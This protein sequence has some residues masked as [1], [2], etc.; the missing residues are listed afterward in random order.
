MTACAYIPIHLHRR[1]AVRRSGTGY[2]SFSGAEAPRREPRG[3]S[4]AAGRVGGRGISLVLN[5]FFLGSEVLFPDLK[6]FSMALKSF[7]LDSEVLFL[8]LKSFSRG[9]I[10]QVLNETLIFS[11]ADP[12]ADSAREKDFRM[13]L[14]ILGKVRE[15][16]FRMLKSFSPGCYFQNRAK[17][18]PEVLFTDV[19]SFSLDRILK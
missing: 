6:S 9:H 2:R 18:H 10:L 16:D 5:S 12:G 3:R 7:S 14:P 15:K 8:R 1:L 19:K 13:I 11:V 17:Y 4:Q